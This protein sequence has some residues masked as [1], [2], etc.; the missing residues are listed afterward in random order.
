MKILQHLR[1]VLLGLFLLFWLTL[2]CKA[3]TQKFQFPRGSHDTFSSGCDSRGEMNACATQ[4][5]LEADPLSLDDSCSHLRR[6]IKPEIPL[7]RPF[8]SRPTFSRKTN[9]KERA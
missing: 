7:S 3:D 4:C 9:R 5:R 6:Q 8:R 2:T 1:G